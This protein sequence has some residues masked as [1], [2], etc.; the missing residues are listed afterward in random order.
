MMSLA[1]LVMALAIVVDDAVVGADNITRHL[2]LRRSC[3]PGNPSGT[4]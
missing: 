1:G 3:Q 4:P 2:R